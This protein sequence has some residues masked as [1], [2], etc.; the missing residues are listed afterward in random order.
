MA[1]AGI[2]RQ[3]KVARV[4]ARVTNGTLGVHVRVGTHGAAKNNNT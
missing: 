4:A 3:A 1:R 2:F